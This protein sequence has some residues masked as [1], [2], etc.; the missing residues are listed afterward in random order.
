MEPVPYEI[1]SDDIDEVLTAYE[2]ADG[3]SEEQRATL[4]SHV[5]SHVTELDEIIRT[6]PERDPS[7]DVR[8]SAM[9]EPVNARPGA[10]SSA[11]RELALAAIEDLLI[12]EQLVDAGADE[13]RIFPVIDDARRSE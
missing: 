3:W 10:A 5:M 8:T 13:R 11:R 6:A 12:R 7:R 4:R 1:R 2:P 9:A